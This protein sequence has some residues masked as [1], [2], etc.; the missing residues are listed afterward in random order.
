MERYYP[1]SLEE[2]TTEDFEG[3]LE[4]KARTSPIL[5]DFPEMDTLWHLFRFYR[6]KKFNVDDA[7]K[8][9]RI[10]ITFRKEANI[11]RIM[12]RDHEDY[13]DIDSVVES[14]RYGVDKHGR[15]IIIER[16]AYTD[17]KQLMK[18]KYEA[19]RFDYFIQRYERLL[20]I[21]LP[22]ASEAVNRKID[23][24]IVITDLE[25]VSFSKMFDSKLKA[26]FKLMVIIGQNNYPE[27][28]EHTFIVNVPSMFKG[29]W[30]MLQSWFNKKNSTSV[31]LHN[32][33]PFEKL[34]GYLDVD[35]LPMFLG[36][37][38]T[39]PLKVNHG[40]WKEAIE[41]SKRRRS[42][43]LKDRTI[44]Y[45]YFYTEEEKQDLGLGFGRVKR[46]MTNSHNKVEGISMKDVRHFPHKLHLH[47]K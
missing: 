36:G 17:H 26:F 27:I 5:I 7:E 25:G 23:K 11:D 46:L 16:M 44:E 24:I 22:M 3:L 4:L 37:K 43:F 13:T 33:V 47:K 15:P 9:V 21:E 8:M 42:F 29:M 45:K 32:S 35:S 14:G 41:D 10:F 39:I 19:L 28:T 30:N 20:F 1:K 6:A 18:S 38:N 31:T 2:L 40:P 12:A 34:K